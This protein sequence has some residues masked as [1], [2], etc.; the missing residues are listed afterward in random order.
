MR[1]IRKTAP[2]L[3][4]FP[5]PEGTWEL[6][7]QAVTPIYKGGSNPKGIDEG[8]PFRGPSLKGLL[9]IWWRATQETRDVEDLR[10]REG[11]LFGEIFGSGQKA[12]R[13]S[14]GITLLKSTPT[15]TPA[16]LGW[17][18]W[19]TR[20]GDEKPFHADGATGQLRVRTNGTTDESKEVEKA[21]RALLLFGGVGSRT[22]RGLGA[23]WT[24]DTV[25]LPS[26]SNPGE[27]RKRGVD[28]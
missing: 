17:I 27:L 6:E 3:P 16:D 24:D 28:G 13:V 18:T 10:H 25:L 15:G 5:T 11:D 19:V 26:F 12:S 14:L 4:T 20:R 21:L 2:E 9:R 1:D 23:L 22:R 8:I 7:I